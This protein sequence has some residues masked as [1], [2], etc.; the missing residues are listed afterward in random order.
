MDQRPGACAVAACGARAKYECPRCAIR[1]CG[2]PCYRKHSAR[3]VAA[4]A[5]DG[6]AH[7]RGVTVSDVDRRKSNR[8][9]RALIEEVDAGRCEDADK[10]VD[11]TGDSASDDQSS[12]EDVADA[13]ERLAEDLDAETVTFEDALARLPAELAADFDD[14]LLD[15]RIARLLPLWQPWWVAEDAELPP[16]PDMSKSLV[17]PAAARKRA[18][19]IVA[20]SVTAVLCAYCYALRVYNG[21]WASDAGAFVRHLIRHCSVLECDERYET[22]DSVLQAFVT[23]CES[24]GAA[25]AAVHDAAAVYG[26]RADWT[27]RAL[28]DTTRALAAAG[29]RRG[30]RRKAEFLIAWVTGGEDGEFVARARAMERFAARRAEEGMVGRAER[31]VSGAIRYK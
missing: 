30:M 2:V 21:D 18:S 8:T 17:T 3:C 12:V 14:M 4:F 31:A 10:V 15:G 26:G 19:P 5:A 22:D 11:V 23:R 29:V 27:R 24:S 1:Y 9:L 7:L 20:H 16:L 13:L 25:M 28:G 6:Q